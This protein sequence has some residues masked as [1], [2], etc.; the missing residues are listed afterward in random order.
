MFS[1][2]IFYTT[3]KFLVF[4]PN[5]PLSTNLLFSS[6]LN[7]TTQH[8]HITIASWMFSIIRINLT[9]N[10]LILI[11]KNSLWLI[12]ALYPFIFQI[13]FCMIHRM[14]IY[15]K[16]LMALANILF[17]VYAGLSFK[18]NLISYK[19]CQQHTCHDKSICVISKWEFTLVSP[20]SL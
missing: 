8:Q 16:M 12:P 2:S 13:L 7:V 14:K 17:S 10:T 11:S 5:L 20:L 9:Q 3:F 18:S 4:L 6:I 15:D 1:K 19:K